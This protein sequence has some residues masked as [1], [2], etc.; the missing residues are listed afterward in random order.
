[1]N[2]SVEIGERGCRWTGD[3]LRRFE[4]VANLARQFLPNSTI[5]NDKVQRKRKCHGRRVR[6]G[7]TVR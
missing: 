5:V 2:D 7:D 3:L 6:P 4:F 1:M